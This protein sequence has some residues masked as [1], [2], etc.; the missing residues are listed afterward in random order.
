MSTAP[1]IR[2]TVTRKALGAMAP[3]IDRDPLDGTER[4]LRAVDHGALGGGIPPDSPGAA[5]DRATD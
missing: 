1:G 5:T 4:L 3:E 2:V